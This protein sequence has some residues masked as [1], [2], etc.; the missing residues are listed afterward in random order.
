MQ[1]IQ[2]KGQQAGV[3]C[4]ICCHSLKNVAAKEKWAKTMHELEHTIYCSFSYVSQF[5]QPLLSHGVGRPS[6]GG[7]PVHQPP[8]TFL[9][10][11][12]L[13]I[14]IVSVS[15]YKIKSIYLCV[16]YIYTVP[17]ESFACSYLWTC[18]QKVHVIILPVNGWH[19]LILP[20]HNL[21]CVFEGCEK[22]KMLARS[23][24]GRV[25]HLIK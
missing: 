21:V 11:H 18:F 6:S 16:V 17:V 13:G 14:A 15:G 9:H 8:S 25:T 23:F 10:M 2:H 20:K 12:N 4:E 1:K 19:T 22:G 3:T 5:P 24:K 7:F